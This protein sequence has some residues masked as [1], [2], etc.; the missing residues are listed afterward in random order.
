[1]GIIIQSPEIAGAAVDRSKLRLPE[2][3]YRVILTEQGD[4]AWVESS[5]DTPIIYTKEPKTSWG[6]RLKV[7]LY[8]I[9]PIKGQL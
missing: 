4:L 6:R 7:G 2:V 9:L 1:M 8:G 5:G 3:A